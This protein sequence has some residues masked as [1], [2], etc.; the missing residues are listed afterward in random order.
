MI[1]YGTYQVEKQRDLQEPILD[2]KK[3]HLLYAGTFDPRKGGAAAAVAAASALSEQYHVHIIGFGSERDK[4]VLLEQ[5]DQVSGTAKATVS[6]DGLLSGEE[7]IRFVQSCDVG[8]STQTP[9]GIYNETSFPSKVLSY[10]ANGLRVVS[11]KIKVL[12]RSEISDLIS[13]YEENTPKAIA[14][15][16]KKI[17][18]SEPYDSRGIIGVL[19]HKFVHALN[20]LLEKNDIG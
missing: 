1:I 11:V 10:M 15:A 16:V 19:D 12:E 8:F 3:I 5:I 7:Y 20:R 17:D 2:P 4:A 14:D 6:Y 18:F 13:Y 9:D